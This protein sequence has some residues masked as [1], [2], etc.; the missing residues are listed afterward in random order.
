MYPTETGAGAGAHCDPECPQH[1]PDIDWGHRDPD[2]YA[3][4]GD[5][6][7]QI[8]D[9]T[10]PK[11]DNLE[12]SR[13]P[14]YVAVVVGLLRPE[15]FEQAL[16]LAGLAMGLTPAETRIEMANNANPNDLRRPSGLSALGNVAYE[17]VLVW[18]AQY[19]GMSVGG[20]K[21]FH[22]PKEWAR[23]EELYET[24]GLVLALVYDGGDLST[25]LNGREYEWAKMVTPGLRELDKR[26]K[27]R[28]LFI[29]PYTHWWSGVYKIPER[30]R[31]RR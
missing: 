13:V 8:T 30:R 4:L 9:A 7:T 22:A 25:W 28:G 29:E 26:L 20:N 27:K 12:G 5:V 10:P 21:T 14:L 24:E 1:Y 23:H 19:S 3:V 15:R 2:A 6:F 31:R 18:M 17:T 16:E 11:D